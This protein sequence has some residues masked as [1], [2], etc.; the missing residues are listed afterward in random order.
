MMGVGIGFRQLLIGPF[1][2]VFVRVQQVASSILFSSYSE[3][4]RSNDDSIPEYSL[5]TCFSIRQRLKALICTR[6]L[7]VHWHR[8]RKLRKEVIVATITNTYC[9][10]RK[11]NGSFFLLLLLLVRKKKKGKY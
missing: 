2:S 5:G 10:E 8:D 6:I 4:S 3:C 7:A 11:K 9:G 1:R